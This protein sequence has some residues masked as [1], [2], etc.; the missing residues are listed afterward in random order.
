[1]RRKDADTRIQFLVFGVFYETNLVLL[2]V[3]E[4]T[5]KVERK[6]EVETGIQFSV[7]AGAGAANAH[8]DIFEVSLSKALQGE[9][10][11]DHSGGM[12]VRT[13]RI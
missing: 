13:N 10:D 9:R 12:L 11:R 6:V 1:M 5:K 4:H 8:H 2:R 3:Q 7:L